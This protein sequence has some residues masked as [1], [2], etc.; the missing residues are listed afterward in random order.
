MSKTYAHFSDPA[1]A[2]PGVSPARRILLIRVMTIAVLVAVWEAVSA[3][4]LLYKGVVP[5][6]SLIIPAF[7]KLIMSSELYGNLL[8]TL[9]EVLSGIVIAAVIAIPCGLLFGARRFLG[10]AAEPY[11]NA[12]ATTPKI[13]FLPIVMLMVGIGPE[14]KIALGALSA[15]FPIVL[16][17]ISGVI[18]VRRVHLDVGRSFN[19]STLQMV[20]KIYL[21]SLVLPILTGLR[22]GL[23]VC[24]IGVLL[25]E[26]KLSNAGLGF[27][28]NDFYNLYLIPDLYAVLILIFAL[29]VAAN[30][31]MEAVAKRFAS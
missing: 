4:G 15:V 22:L 19:L 13:V 31:L 27:L 8:V 25:G 1:L 21:P 10:R 20:T 29:A 23:G 3:S 6:F 14:S 16:S 11:I 30:V 9:S 17:I 26:I 28:A 18:Q 24:I 12:L 5:S 2:R 7:F